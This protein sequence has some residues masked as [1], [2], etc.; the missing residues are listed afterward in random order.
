MSVIE[1][2][3]ARVHFLSDIFVPVVVG[4]AKATYNHSTDVQSPTHAL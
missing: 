4:V 1:F 2:E 3:A